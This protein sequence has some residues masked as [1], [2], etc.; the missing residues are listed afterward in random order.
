LKKQKLREKIQY[1]LR[2][3][4]IN[5]QTKE[6]LILHQNYQPTLNQVVHLNLNP[7]DLQ[8]QFHQQTTMKREN[9]L[10]KGQLKDLKMSLKRRMV[11]EKLA[12][13]EEN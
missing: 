4:R 3:K 6:L 13:K 10:N 1:L 8:N 11:K 12:Q 7:Q 5:F 9:L 2:K